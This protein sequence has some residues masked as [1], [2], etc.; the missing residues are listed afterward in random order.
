MR[1]ALRESLDAACGMFGF[2]LAAAGSGVVLGLVIGGVVW[3]VRTL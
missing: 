2:V 3:V 1:D